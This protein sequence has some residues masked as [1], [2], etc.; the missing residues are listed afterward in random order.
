[1]GGCPFA[2]MWATNDNCATSGLES[3]FRRSQSDISIQLHLQA[4]TTSLHRVISTPHIVS[5]TSTSP[6]NDPPLSS[7]AQPS[8]SS[9]ANISVS[10]AL[11]SSIHIQRLT[12]RQLRKLG[13]CWSLAEVRQHAA[14]DDAWIVVDSKVYDITEH[15]LNHPGWEDTAA[16]STVLSI[17]AHAGT[18]CTQVR[19]CR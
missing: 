5:E 14:K 3:E 2:S 4:P 16:I 11:N 15:L 10:A 17:L 6:P 7:S 1:M 9:S 18:D 13:K 19:C 12:R 8:R